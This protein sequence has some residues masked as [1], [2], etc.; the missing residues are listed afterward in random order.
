M[1]DREEQI[2]HLLPLVRRVARRIA[3]VVG[4]T[5][6]D[7]LIGDG[8][9]GLI[10]AV[11]SFDPSRGLTL[12][13]Y[14]RR[15]VAGAMLNG[16][17]RLDPVSERVRRTLRDAERIRYALA[18]ER[19]ELPSM[20][21]MEEHVPALKRARTEAHRGTPVSIDAPFPNGERFEC[22]AV[23]DPQ[24]VAAA[25][26]ERLRVHDAIAELPLR[27]RRLVIAHYFAERSLRTLSRDMNVSPQRVSQ[28]HLSAIGRMRRGIAAGA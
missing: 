6:V 13:Q 9:V 24:T 7:D 3:R 14:A 12:E 4:G 19:G 20:R 8:S 11:D 15:I 5:D 23:D 25:R 26:A 2:R 17:R 21:E 18:T 28:L 16:I 1:I 10:R 27:E 22:S